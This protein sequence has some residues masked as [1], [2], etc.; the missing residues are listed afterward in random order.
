MIVKDQISPKKSLVRKIS[1][2]KK[3]VVGEQ[4]R[5]E[6]A[7][8]RYQLAL[9]SSRNN[10][11]DEA[12]KEVCRIYPPLS[13]VKIWFKK[14]RHLYDTREDF[15]QDYLRIFC[16]ALANWQPR[17]LRRTNR[18]NGSGEFKNFFWSSLSHHY[19]NQVKAEA[20]GKR[21]LAARCPICDV[22]CNSHP[23]S[24]HLRKCHQ[25]LM[26]D[27][28]GLFGYP[29]DT[30]VSCPFCKSH[31]V[32]RQVACS[33][34]VPVSGSQC[35]ICLRQA[36]Q[37]SIRKHLLSMHSTYLFERFRELYPQH[38]TLSPKPSAVY[39]TDDKNEE[40]EVNIYDIIPDDSNS[41]NKLLSFS[42][43]D[44]Q[45][46]ILYRVFNGAPQVVYEPELYNCSEGEFDKELEELKN[47]M[48]LCGLEG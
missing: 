19:I 8:I 34:E 11:I 12:Y 48:S 3:V 15:V 39:I 30:L 14:Y 32:P 26:W 20:A 4:I 44:I 25:D 1:K 37:V 2:S 43:T 9:K 46:K 40:D 16:S 6:D 41:I 5:L 31:K 45:Q 27:Q 38:A 18:Y 42:L 21:T 47:I 28:M 22:W 29:V 36:Q 10:D 33:C 24:T 23:L 13:F 17:H 7:I 35:E